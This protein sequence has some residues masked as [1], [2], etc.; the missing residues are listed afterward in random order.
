MEW[1]SQ[2]EDDIAHLLIVSHIQKFAIYS[3]L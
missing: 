2:R 1:H 3:V